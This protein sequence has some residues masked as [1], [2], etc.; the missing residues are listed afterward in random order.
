MKK[1]KVKINLILKIETKNSKTD[2]NLKNMNKIKRA[3][4]MSIRIKIE[5]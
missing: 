3:T 5:T 1:Q 4:A 2:L